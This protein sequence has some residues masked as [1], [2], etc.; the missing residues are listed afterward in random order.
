MTAV[1]EA[2]KATGVHPC[3]DC[4]GPCRGLRCRICDGK[5]R[6]AVNAQK[7]KAERAPKPPMLPL[8]QRYPVPTPALNDRP[9]TEDELDEATCPQTDPDIFFAELGEGYHDA[10]KVC[11]GCPIAA[12]CLAWALTEGF[13]YGVFGG[14]SPPERKRILR[15][16]RK[17]GA[18]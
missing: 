4:G 5:Y 13:E 9:L 6:R 18:A 15:T 11:Y 3:Q 17:R 10:K 16:R 2:P 12:R 7:P 1:I 14:A 8:S